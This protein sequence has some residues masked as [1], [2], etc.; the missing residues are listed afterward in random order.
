MNATAT[1]IPSVEPAS[2]PRALLPSDVTEE[3][4]RSA[5]PGSG[6]ITY[7]D[8]YNPKGHQ[9]EIHIANWLY[10]EFG[11]DIVLLKESKE[12]GDR[13]PDYHWN[14]RS[15]EL[16]GVTSKNS[17]DRAIREAAKLIQKNPG[18]IILDTSNRELSDEAIEDT[19]FQRMR[20]AALELVDILIVSDEKL[21][22]ILRYKR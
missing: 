13:T 12:Q 3:Y 16:K 7:E 20:R 17:V 10:S 2:K 19:I 8:G 4:L 9:A 15:W 6:T 22:K 18:G 21:K 14:G 5:A 1:P 11:G